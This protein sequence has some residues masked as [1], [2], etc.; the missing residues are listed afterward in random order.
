ML[1][2][3][4]GKQGTTEDA[5][6]PETATAPAGAADF[7]EEKT[8]SAIAVWSFPKAELLRENAAVRSHGHGRAI[9]APP[10]SIHGT[11]QDRR[12]NA[13]KIPKRKRRHAGQDQ[14]T[15]GFQHIFAA[16][17]QQGRLGKR[18]GRAGAK[19][20]N[21]THQ[22]AQHLKKNPIENSG[23]IQQNSTSCSSKSAWG[24]RQPNLH[25]PL[26]VLRPLD[27]RDNATEWAPHKLELC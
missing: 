9:L 10:Q 13:Q 7:V 23:S 14:R 3:L 2:P 6:P 12:E 8:G 16:P 19:R 11:T 15:A 17:F 27:R 26:H 24:K 20:S 5:A 25:A 22:R 18:W 1:H 21:A 4:D